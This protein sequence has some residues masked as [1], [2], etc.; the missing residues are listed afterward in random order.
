MILFLFCVMVGLQN[1]PDVDL[2]MGSCV[3]SVPLFNQDLGLSKEKMEEGREA[4]GR[5][6]VQRRS[7]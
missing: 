2:L 6:L 3:P 4:K 7:R 5:C 1:Q